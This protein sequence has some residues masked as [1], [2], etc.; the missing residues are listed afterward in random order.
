MSR[1]WKYHNISTS[2]CRNITIQIQHLFFFSIYMF[3]HHINSHVRRVPTDIDDP[4][5]ESENR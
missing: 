4:G 2:V 5:Y 3:S 1:M